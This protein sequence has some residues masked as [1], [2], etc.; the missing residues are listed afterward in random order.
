MWESFYPAPSQPP[1]LSA[2]L[3]SWIL[4]MSISGSGLIVSLNVNI[5]KIIFKKVIEKLSKNIVKEK[6]IDREEERFI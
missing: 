2:S 1:V 3:I 6:I 4:S 5:L